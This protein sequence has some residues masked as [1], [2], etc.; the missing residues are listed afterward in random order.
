[1][2]AWPPDFLGADRPATSADD[3]DVVHADV[4]LLEEAAPRP[5]HSPLAA[6]AAA[7]DGA[8]SREATAH[9]VG[10]LVAGFLPRHLILFRATTAGRR[11]SLWCVVSRS[12]RGV[13]LPQSAQRTPL[14]L[15]VGNLINT[16]RASEMAPASLTEGLARLPRGGRGLP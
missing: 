4:G 15:S 7:A 2:S 5:Y 3:D 8:L 9:F 11:A 13:P 6:A 10:R 16:A 12:P 14:T 1:M